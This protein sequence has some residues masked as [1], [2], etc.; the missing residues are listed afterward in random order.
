M[1]IGKSNLQEWV[2]V[3]F[4]HRQVAFANFENS[5]QK[6]TPPQISPRVRP[7]YVLHKW[8]LLCFNPELNLHMFMKIKIDCWRTPWSRNQLKG[9]C[10]SNPST[11]TALLSARKG[12]SDC[13]SHYV[14]NLSAC[15]I[16]FGFLHF[17]SPWTLSSFH[18][19]VTSNQCITWYL[20]LSFW[21][22]E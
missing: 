21:S 6:C 5:Y 1:W 2:G 12:A 17:L 3:I 9:I 11:G 22:S 13:V 14:E 8:C 20:F 19:T 15:S 16:N 4:Y 7:L 10:L 18:W